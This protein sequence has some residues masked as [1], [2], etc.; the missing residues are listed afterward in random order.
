MLEFQ[1]AVFEKESSGNFIRAR[2]S[3][4]FDLVCSKVR[5]VSKM[6]YIYP[7]KKH[8]LL[9][10]NS[11]QFYKTVELRITSLVGF[12]NL[13]G[14]EAARH[15]RQTLKICENTLST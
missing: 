15:A 4:Y 14:S 2:V 12:H 1:Y 5:A 3:L 10:N 11:N 6:I 7:V 9:G 13:K 8:K